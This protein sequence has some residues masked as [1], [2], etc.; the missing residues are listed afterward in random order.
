MNKQND[1]SGI[2]ARHKK[3]VTKIKV[4]NITVKIYFDRHGGGKRKAFR[5]QW[6]N[7]DGTIGREMFATYEE[8]WVSPTKRRRI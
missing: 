8:A 6:D 4:G 5:V 7:P 3:R 2:G 1:G